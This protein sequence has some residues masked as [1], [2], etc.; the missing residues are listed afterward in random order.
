MKALRTRLGAAVRSTI[1]THLA[2][3]DS[4]AAEPSAEEDA[5]DGKVAYLTRRQAAGEA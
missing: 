3:L 1:E 5:L 4:L 2:L